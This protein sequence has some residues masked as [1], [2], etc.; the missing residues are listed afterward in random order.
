MRMAE[1]PEQV[2]PEAEAAPIPPV[3]GEPLMKGRQ[4]QR[5]ETQEAHPLRPEVRLQGLSLQ[6]TAAVQ[7][8]GLQKQAEHLL[9]DR[10]DI[11]MKEDLPNRIVLVAEKV[12]ILA[13]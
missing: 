12:L 13:N 7:E 1:I 5:Q 3:V 8:G 4:E 10:P 11:I 9:P 6:E 2:A